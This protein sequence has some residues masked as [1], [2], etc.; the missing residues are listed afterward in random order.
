MFS[1]DWL[2]HIYIYISLDDIIYIKIDVTRSSKRLAARSHRFPSKNQRNFAGLPPALRGFG[3]K[4]ILV[5]QSVFL[6]PLLYW[7]NVFLP[8]WLVKSDVFPQQNLR[9]GVF[10][11][12]KLWCDP[13][14]AATPG[15]GEGSGAFRCRL[16]MRFRRVPVQ[17]A[18]EVPDS[19]GA[20]GWWSSGGFRCR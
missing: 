5:K 10:S 14:Q 12:E 20:A 9:T 15:S 3:W 1:D 18:D 4:N 13:V 17:M 2:I 16:L 19:S 11:P 6:K 7:K 8:I